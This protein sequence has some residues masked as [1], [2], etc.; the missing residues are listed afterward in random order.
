MCL[1]LATDHYLGIALIDDRQAANC[2]YF[3]VV[4]VVVYPFLNIQ[5]LTL[6]VFNEHQVM[7]KTFKLKIYQSINQP[8]N[9]SIRCPALY[10][11]R[12]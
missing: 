3:E 1:G 12:S 7:R 5:L 10:R 11:R 9:Q 6:N 2:K 8:I 4:V